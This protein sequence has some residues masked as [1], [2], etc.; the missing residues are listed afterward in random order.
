M[1]P[2]PAGPLWPS[3]R[4]LAAFLMELK[5]P[6]ISTNTSLARPT[7][8]H[9]STKPSERLT[10]VSNIQQHHTVR[11]DNRQTHAHTILS[12]GYHSRARASRR[13]TNHHTIV[14]C[15]HRCHV[16]CAHRARWTRTKRNPAEIIYVN[17]DRVLIFLSFYLYLRSPFG[18]CLVMTLQYAS[19]WRRRASRRFS[20]RTRM[21]PA[22]ATC[23]CWRPISDTSS[24]TSEITNHLLYC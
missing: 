3:V 7:H 8:C 5:N 4:T 18:S 16:L 6:L 10:E 17:R 11:T 14:L 9:T 15:E 23:T 21:L 24:P 1:L 22:R 20:W 12:G 2:I 13:R 19:R